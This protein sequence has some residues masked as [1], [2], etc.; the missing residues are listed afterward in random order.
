MSA[1][2]GCIQGKVNIYDGQELFSFTWTKSG[3]PTVKP[4][5]RKGFGSSILNGLAKHFAQD[6]AANYWPGR[7]SVYELRIPLSRIRGS[8]S[9]SVLDVTSKAAKLHRFEQASVTG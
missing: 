8:K 4:P 5:T 6:V 1:R 9:A 7:C 3:G 2:T